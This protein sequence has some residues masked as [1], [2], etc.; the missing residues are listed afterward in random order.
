MLTQYFFVLLNLVFFAIVTTFAVSY[1]PIFT[2]PFFLLMFNIGDFLGKF[3]P[4][5]FTTSKMT[6]VYLISLMF[7]IISVYYYF[8]YYFTEKGHWI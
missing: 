7:P 1:N 4:S 6:T 8:F 5:T 3:I 2:L